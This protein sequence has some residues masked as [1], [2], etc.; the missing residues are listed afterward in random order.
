MNKFED[1]GVHYR[2]VPEGRAFILEVQLQNG[3]V[4]PLEHH[5]LMYQVAR[6]LT[7]GGTARS[8]SISFEDEMVVSQWTTARLW[9]A[10]RGDYGYPTGS[11]PYIVRGPTGGRINIEEYPCR[12]LRRAIRFAVYWFADALYKPDW[13]HV[14]GPNDR[15]IL[16]NR[17]LL[18][19]YRGMMRARGEPVVER[20]ARM[21]R[22]A[23]V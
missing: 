8:A 15:V 20:L 13:V 11:T 12:S 23:A 5:R 6:L 9:K 1:C 14:V 7:W 17:E 2:N 18:R 22:T 10:A 21:R 4:V 16:S 3:G 19:M